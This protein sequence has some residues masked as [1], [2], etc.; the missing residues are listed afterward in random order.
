MVSISIVIPLYNKETYIGRT[1]Q[2]V[3]AQTFQDFE[4]IIIDDGST[5][6]GADVV[7]SFQDNRIKLFQQE[8][9]GVSIARNKG[10]ALAKSDFIAFLDADDEWLPGHL[11]ALSQLRKKFP[12][13]GAFTT[14]YNILAPDG[15][16]RLA[17]YQAIPESP[18]EL[19]LPNFFKS[20]A[21]GDSPLNS[22]SFG[23]PKPIF[24]EVGG[25]P[26]NVGWG[27]DTDLFGR[28]ALK[29][30]IAFSWVIGTIYHWDSL[31]RAC[32]RPATSEDPFINTFEQGLKKGEIPPEFLNDIM[33]YIARK[34]LYQAL[35]LILS[36]NSE[37][38]R[39]ILRDCDTKLFL[40]NKSL[41]LFLTFFP[42]QLSALV[43]DYY[44]RMKEG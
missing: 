36:G 14:A 28:I 41:L 23:I 39:K 40:W 25:F 44:F 18:R 26:E 8:N 34:K 30:P 29:Y 37:E 17:N 4:I 5:D 22:S 10:V 9:K 2:S 31:N 38:A 24:N 7:R 6:N 11:N 3:L 1:L 42:K 32:R 13:A 35:C 21:M 33:E 43:A 27:E 16:L 12:E 15:Q 19:L 20:A